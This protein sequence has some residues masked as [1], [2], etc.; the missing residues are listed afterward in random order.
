MLMIRI[1]LAFLQNMFC[2]ILY[3]IHYLSYNS[4]FKGNE[5]LAA[6][7]KDGADPFFGRSHL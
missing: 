3:K 6:V 2:T 5:T 4:F 1:S 7:S